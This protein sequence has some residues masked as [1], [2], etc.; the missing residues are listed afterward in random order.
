LW[1]LLEL[2]GDVYA[3]DV[4][5]TGASDIRLGADYRAAKHSFPA[6]SASSV[7]TSLIRPRN[8]RVLLF[9]PFAAGKVIESIKLIDMLLCIGL[10]QQL[11]HYKI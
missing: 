5:F 10:Y 4:G 8:K 1:C 11:I 3:I 2:L 9:A 6:A 7:T